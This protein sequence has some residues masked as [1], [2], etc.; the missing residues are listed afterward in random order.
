M[1]LD[2]AARPTHLLLVSR[3]RLLATGL[4]VLVLHPPGQ[5][6]LTLLIREISQGLVDNS[7]SCS[8]VA[9]HNKHKLVNLIFSK[10]NSVAPWP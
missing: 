10:E 5:L 8:K 9:S 3:M 7:N 2:L 6:H 1:T 4:L